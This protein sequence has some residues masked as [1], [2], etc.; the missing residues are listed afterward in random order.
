MFN[1]TDKVVMSINDTETLSTDVVC[2]DFSKAFN[3]V[4]HDLILDKL[5]TYY[6]IDV[7]LLK[8]LKNYLC[9]REQRVVLDGVRSPAKP[10]LSEVPRG[11]I[12]GPI[13]FVLFIN[14]L[15]QGISTDTRVAL[16]A[17]DTKIWRSIK[18]E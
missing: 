10:V 5:K 7:R 12:L 9:D 8:F 3:S 6:S 2:L 14:D 16:Y 18:N 11:S 15:H 13:L 1:F 4:N 17:D